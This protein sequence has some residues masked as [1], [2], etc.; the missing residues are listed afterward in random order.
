MELLVRGCHGLSLWKTPD[1]VDGSMLCAYDGHERDKGAA[2]RRLEASQRIRL[3]Q[4]FELRF[5]LR[6]VLTVL[7]SSLQQGLR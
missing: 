6:T 4:S 3:L 5:E 1:V 7:S 2:G